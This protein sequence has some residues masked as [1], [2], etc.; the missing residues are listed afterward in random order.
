M[1]LAVPGRVDELFEKNGLTMGR[2]NYA[3]TLKEAC[4]A[5]LPE[6]EIGQYVV[7]HAGFAISALN[8]SEAERTLKLWQTMADGAA[9]EGL[10]LYGHPLDLEEDS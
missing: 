7:V 5:Y 9:K 4:L 10:D 8:E 3:G 1:C 2:I 6:I